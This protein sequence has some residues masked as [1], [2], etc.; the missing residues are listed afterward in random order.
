MFSLL[1]LMHFATSEAGKEECKRAYLYSCMRPE[2][3]RN[4][5]KKD[6]SWPFMLVSLSFS[7]EALICLRSGALNESCNQHESVLLALHEFH[8]SLMHHFVANLGATPDVH[9]ALLLSDLRKRCAT[10]PLALL[11][12]YK[13]S[14]AS[15]KG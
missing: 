9:H 14:H 6:L 15:K 7:K 13:L 4:G 1:Q 12:E 2:H 11:S 10:E 8:R 3:T 5:S